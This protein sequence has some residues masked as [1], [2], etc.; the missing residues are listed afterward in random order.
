MA[1]HSESKHDE[2]LIDKMIRLHKEG[3]TY[4]DIAN[5]CKVCKQTVRNHISEYTGIPKRQ[6]N[7]VYTNCKTET[8]APT[9]AVSRTTILESEVRDLKTQISKLKS[10]YKSS[11]NQNAKQK[12]D[13]ITL[14]A[15]KKN[16]RQETIAITKEYD[17]VIK[18]KEKYKGQL[19]RI[20]IEGYETPSLVLKIQTR[21]VKKA[22][23]KNLFLA[24]KDA[25]GSIHKLPF[26]DMI[27]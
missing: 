9:K 15:E 18:E 26:T 6:Y 4:D 25:N 12:T 19:E 11:Q 10:L 21:L 16:A 7:R 24:G 14:E 17:R 1:T 2:S 8:T 23:D 20:S 5:E 22:E 27:D 3:K 13:M